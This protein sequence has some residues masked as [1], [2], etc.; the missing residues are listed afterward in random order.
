MLSRR[1][2]LRRLTAALLATAT[3]L[4]SCAANPGPPPIVE[5]TDITGEDRANEPPPPQPEGRSQVNVAVQPL[6]NGL[7]P[8]LLAD[9]NS[10][11][12]AVADLVLPSPFIGGQ[13]NADLIDDAAVID[14]PDSAPS[15]TL[16]AVRYTISTS[17]Q[18]SDGT[19]LTGKDFVY[20]W[21][22]MRN[23]PGVID[24]AGY[25]VISDVRVSG[26]G[27]KVVDVYFTQKVGNWQELF[28]HLLPSHLLAADSSD[29]ATALGQTIPA[30]AG[31]YRVED[32]DHSRG[33]ITLNRND[34]FWSTSPAAID[35]V[36]IIAARSTDQV[37]DQ[38]RSQQIAFLDQVPAETSRQTYELIPQTQVRMID[39]SRV[40]GVSMSPAS[41]I[42]ADVK[43]RK[44][45]EELIDVP[46]ISRIATG[47]STDLAVID[48]D[49][50]SGISTSAGSTGG[51]TGT[52]SASTSSTTSSIDVDELR[53]LIDA[54]RPLRI[55]AD[56][57]DAQAMSAA[58][59]LVDVLN[60]KGIPS[61]SVITDLPDL[62][63][64]RFPTGEVDV[65][66]RWR[67]QSGTPV[68]LAS[69]LDCP[70]VDATAPGDGEA[71]ELEKTCS[72]E[73]QA[74]VTGILAG[75]VSGEQAKAAV[76][77]A[78]RD[79]AIWLPLMRE[80]R[81]QA[82]GPGVVG[83]DPDFSK[84]GQGLEG[85]ATW[86]LPGTSGTPGS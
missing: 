50:P 25:Q 4:A 44:E 36:R 35:I 3:M 42:L 60:Q 81:V 23:T 85:A 82:V 48:P 71:G 77:A 43:R 86:Q 80:R 51:T 13:R 64:R 83:P 63:S 31:R 58:R 62:V 37:A 73:T 53:A 2:R 67:V 70:P 34:R 39:S 16:M 55:G 20:L 7:N 11:V 6:K 27:G 21:R 9:E 8:H 54:N 19:P 15:G 65:L 41:P 56:P 14:V 72:P 30:S 12:E 45:L 84:W 76:A 68:S 46:L 22:G 10:T 29:F 74:L 32:V 79:N 26:A 47:R 28:T 5:H 57:R 24:A 17:A 33:T 59:A 78:V 38:L 66:V 61:E 69:E 75:D 1:A 40:L 18:W 49:G 52:E